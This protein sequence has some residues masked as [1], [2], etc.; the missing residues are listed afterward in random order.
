MAELKAWWL[1]LMK[2]STNPIYICSSCQ[3]LLE[4]GRWDTFLRGRKTGLHNWVYTT[5]ACL[6][7]RLSIK[8]VSPVQQHKT[9]WCHTELRPIGISTRSLSKSSGLRQGYSSHVHRSLNY[10]GNTA[11]WRNSIIP[12]FPMETSACLLWRG[13]YCPFPACFQWPSLPSAS[14]LCDA[15]TW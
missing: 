9:V 5:L 12:W 4:A 7:D 8:P 1:C 3:L 13:S 11:Q 15:T 2:R 10:L 6:C 14:Q